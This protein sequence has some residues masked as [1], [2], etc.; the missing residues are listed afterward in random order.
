MID[1]FLLMLCSNDVS[2]LHRFGDITTFT[3]HVTACD[4]D[5]S[6]SFDKIVEIITSHVRFSTQ[7]QT[8][9]SK[10]VLNFMRT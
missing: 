8:Y 10:Y 2:I 9:R 4:L 3:V 7:M 5:K 6:F 1:D